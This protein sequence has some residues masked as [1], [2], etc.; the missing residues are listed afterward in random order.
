MTDDEEYITIRLPR[1]HW[2]A[3]RN[4]IQ[5]WANRDPNDI[6]ILTDITTLDTPNQSTRDI[7]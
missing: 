6:E 5:K 4:G 7:E 1:S 3:I 2:V